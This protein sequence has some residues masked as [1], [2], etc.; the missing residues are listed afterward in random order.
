MEFMIREERHKDV[1]FKK[2]ASRQKEAN[3]LI[4]LR[5]EASVKIL[6]SGIMVSPG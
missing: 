3:S 6:M 5:D 1:F 2:L 4:E